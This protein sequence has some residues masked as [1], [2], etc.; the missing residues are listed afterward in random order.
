M[1]NTAVRRTNGIPGSNAAEQLEALGGPVAQRAHRPADARSNPQPLTL[2]ER[3]PLPPADDL[4]EVTADKVDDEAPPQGDVTTFWEQPVRYPVAERA[5][6]LQAQ[7]PRTTEDQPAGSSS[8]SFGRGRSQRTR[9]ST[10]PLRSGP[11]WWFPVSGTLLAVI[12]LYMVVFWVYTFGV[13]AYNRLSYGPTPSFHLEA[14]VGEQ[15]TADHP[16]H[17]FAMN[18]HGHILIQVAP[19]GDFTHITTYTLP[20]LSPKMWGDLD[21]IAITLAVAPGTGNILIHLTGLPDFWHF[22]MRPTLTF[23]LLNLR[24]KPGFVLGPALDQ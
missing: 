8:S 18:L 23:T 5:R 24:P 3:T 7:T 1:A 14:V 12:L 13:L 2:K 21:N 15:D 19:S 4:E 16:T 20:A 6:R 11:S 10:E 17:L 9:R 22:D